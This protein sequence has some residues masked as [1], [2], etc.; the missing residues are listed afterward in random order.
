MKIGDNV[1]FTDKT[2]L[3]QRKGIIKKFSEDGSKA[4]V[5]VTGK[6]SKEWILIDDLKPVKE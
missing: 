2:Y 1:I 5:S 6:F 4:M 3:K